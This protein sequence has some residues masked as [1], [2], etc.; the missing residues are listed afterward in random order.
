ME[1]RNTSRIATIAYIAAAVFFVRLLTFI[2]PG[3]SNSSAANASA[4]TALVA[5]LICILGLIPHLLLFPVVDALPAPRWAKAAGYGW[6]VIDMATD[7][8]QLNGVNSTIYLSLKYGGHISCAI[9]FAAASWQAF[10]ARRVIGLITAID[11]FAFSLLNPLS[12]LM[13]LLL[14]PLII[15]QP[16]WIALSGRA[17]ARQEQAETREQ[18]VPGTPVQQSR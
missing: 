16:L 18:A 17:L 4:G 3:L 1:Q 8:M 11:L 13:F 12:R 5:E 14:I 15:L 6:L 9:W 10:G 7:I 2:V